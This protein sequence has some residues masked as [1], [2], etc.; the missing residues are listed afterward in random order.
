[1]RKEAMDCVDTDKKRKRKADYDKMDRLS[2]LADDL[3]VHILSFLPLKE[4]I[5]ASTLSRRWRFLWTR[6]TTLDFKI[7]HK[8]AFI[9]RALEIV[10]VNHK[11]GL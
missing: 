8:S 3:L 7:Y 10:A 5:S 2:T 4:G 1:M 11:S 9:N 6:M